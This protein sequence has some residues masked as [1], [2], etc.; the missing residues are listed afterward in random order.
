MHAY[1]T[2]DLQTSSSAQ[3]PFC[4]RLSQNLLQLAKQCARM[5]TVMLQSCQDMPLVLLKVQ[6][7]K[8]AFC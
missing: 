7:F 2:P 3:R 4:I 1:Y 5:A 8:H 6:L